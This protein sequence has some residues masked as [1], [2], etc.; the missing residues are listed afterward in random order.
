MINKKDVAILLNNTH[1]KG[2]PNWTTLEQQQAYKHL[3]ELACLW[4]RSEQFS[5]KKEVNNG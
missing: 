5:E 4:F 1:V 2:V 3:K